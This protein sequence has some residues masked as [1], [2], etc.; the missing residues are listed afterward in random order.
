MAPAA[1]FKCLMN[2]HS[3]H[4]GQSLTVAQPKQNISGAG[5][6]AFDLTRHMTAKLQSDGRLASSRANR[7]NQQATADAMA[8]TMM[9]E[10]QHRRSTI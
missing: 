1:P 9:A 4:G 3:S 2:G 5:C 6:S 8:T 10:H 7:T